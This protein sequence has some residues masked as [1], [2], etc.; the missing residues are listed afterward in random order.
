MIGTLLTCTDP[1]CLA[2]GNRVPVYKYTDWYIIHDGASAGICINGCS[3]LITHDIVSE[4]MSYKC[5][6][7]VPNINGRAL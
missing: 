6:S 2:R 1:V 7:V 3:L 4:C 5:M